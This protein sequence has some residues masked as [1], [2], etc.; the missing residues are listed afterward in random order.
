MCLGLIKRIGDGSTTR[1]WTDNWMLR[2]YKLRPI[3]ALTANPPTS[4]AELI[5]PVTRSWD[6]QMLSDNFIALDIEMIINI[7]I[8]NRM[9]DDFWAWHYDRRG[10]FSVRSAYRMITA[11]KA[12]RE[13]WLAHR[14]GH[15]NVAADRSS[16]TQVWKVKVTSKNRLILW[17]L[18]HTSLPTGMVRHQRKITDDPVCSICNAVD[19]SWRHSLLSCTMA[20]CVW[21]L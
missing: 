19:D 1:I 10:V 6:R 16:W 9:Q 3:C 7:P 20:R 5:N 13:D 17:R 12:Q 21:A 8:S 4:V 18:A 2:D 14:S 15:S 11:I